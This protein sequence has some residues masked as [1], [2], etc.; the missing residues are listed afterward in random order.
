MEKI[1]KLLIAFAIITVIGT[2]SICTYSIYRDETI[3]DEQVTLT[4][5][6]IIKARQVNSYSS[7]MS[8]IRRCD[9]SRIVVPTTRIKMVER[10]DS[11]E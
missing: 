4:D 7:G 1:D 6:T 5:G 10:L 9:G 8:D 2:A 3:C 11:A